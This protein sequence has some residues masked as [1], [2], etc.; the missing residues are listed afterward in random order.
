MGGEKRLVG[1][2]ALEQV[3]V[4]GQRDHD[5]GPRL[6]GEV[7]VGAA[8][9]V[10]PARIDDHQRRAGLLRRLDVRYQVDAG[11][12]RVGAPHHDEP[13]VPVVGIGDARHLAVEGLVGGARREGAD[14]AG[15]P[16]RSELSEQPRIDG[17]LGQQAVGPPVREGEDRLGAPRVANLDHPAGDRREGLVPGGA[18]ELAAAA[19]LAD[20]GMGQPGV[21]VH[22]FAEPS[23]LPADVAV[24]DRMLAGAAD[25]HD[26]SPFDRDLEAAGIR[27]VEGANGVDRRSAPSRIVVGSGHRS[28]VYHR[29][30]ASPPR[31]DGADAPATVA[32]ARGQPG[33]HRRRIG[34]P[35]ARGNAP[36]AASPR[37][38]GVG[39]AHAAEAIPTRSV[40]PRAGL[41]APG[42]RRR[43]GPH[44]GAADL[45]FHRRVRVLARGVSDPAAARDGR[46]EPDTA[47]A[48]RLAAARRV[49]GNPRVVRL[50]PVA[51]GAAP[52]ASR[53]RRPR[54]PAHRPGCGDLPGVPGCLGAELPPRDA[55]REA[56][57]HRRSGDRGR[58]GRVGGGRRRASQPVV[59]GYRD[60]GVAAARGAADRSGPG[61][62]ARAARARRVSSR[63]GGSAPAFAVDAL[64]PARRN[65]RDVRPVLAPG[66][67]Q[68][69]R[70]AV[71]AAVRHRA[72]V[73]APG[74]LRPRGGSQ[75]RGVADLPRGRRAHAVQRV[76]E[77][78]GA[79]PGRGP[80]IVA[81]GPRRAA[82]SG[83]PRRLRRGARAHEP[84]GADRPG[85]RA[86]A[87]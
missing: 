35:R 54:G 48:V 13:G 58:P 43:R 42:A 79:A 57:L 83:P 60:A 10:R 1:Q 73:G 65:R 4:H 66:A 74:R 63:A 30:A 84:G 46:D 27:A 28:S 86:P 64:L 21:A 12:R 85:E 78:G 16:R 61:V 38:P 80:G 77:S 45:A 31:R 8:G 15:Q 23:D 69:H 18:G 67:G 40:P 51:S 5:V 37:A 47:G 50:A 7:E 76:A 19:T 70:A 14:R 33:R 56:R 52:P 36:G 29:G 75:L 82:R 34:G 11:A 6:Q 68:R 9:Q 32:A 53:A 22:S 26:R 62:R 24:G 71:R 25:G 72:R 17:V 81:G 41:A 2:I 87:Q 44:G 55:G 3:A 20:Q 59:R 49:G 39:Y